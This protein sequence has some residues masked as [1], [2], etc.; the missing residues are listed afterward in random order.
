MMSVV[1]S[2][3]SRWIASGNVNDTIV[4]DLIG[5]KKR[6]FSDHARAVVGVAFSADGKTIQSASLDGKISYWQRL[7]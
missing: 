6:V 1:F 4:W 2:A 3:D 7:D 5:G